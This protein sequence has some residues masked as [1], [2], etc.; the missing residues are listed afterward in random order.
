[1]C[2]IFSSRCHSHLFLRVPS[3][4]LLKALSLH[5]CLL[6]QCLE[7]PFCLRLSLSSLA[8]TRVLSV[9]Y[10]QQLA[11]CLPQGQ[12]FTHA[13]PLYLVFCCA[14]IVWRRSLPD[15]SQRN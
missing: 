1:M 14:I 9:T 5:P 8:S 12:G 7:V 2:T 10:R 11:D 6:S 3:D 13:L 4:L 15:H